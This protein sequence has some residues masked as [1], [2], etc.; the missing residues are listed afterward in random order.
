MAGRG[1]YIKRLSES[2]NFW[3]QFNFG[4]F[5]FNASYQFIDV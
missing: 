3:L 5:R 1:S 2:V 4:Q